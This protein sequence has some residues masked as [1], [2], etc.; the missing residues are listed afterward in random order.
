[1]IQYIVKA[2]VG[3]DFIDYEF[4]HGYRPMLDLFTLLNSSRAKNSGFGLG[5]CVDLW[6][7]FCT[8]LSMFRSQFLVI[9][10]M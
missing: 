3:Y 7:L 1:M 8:S 6:V 5:T 2:C 10:L 4:M 9:C